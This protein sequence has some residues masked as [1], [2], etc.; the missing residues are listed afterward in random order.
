M[1]KEDELLP[2]ADR[3]EP[4]TYRRFQIS[5]TQTPECMQQTRDILDAID[6]DTKEGRLVY[7]HC[8]GGIGRT[9]T[10]VGCWLS[11]HG[12]PGEDALQ[13]LSELWSANPKSARQNSPENERQRNYVRNWHE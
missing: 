4:S 13:R 5:D 11:R 3:I 9:G 10:I 2:Y 12:Y 7:L 1:T 8:W 6:N